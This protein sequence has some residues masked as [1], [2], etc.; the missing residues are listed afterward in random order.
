MPCSLGGIAFELLSGKYSEKFRKVGVGWGI[1]NERLPGRNLAAIEHGNPAVMYWLGVMV[2]ATLGCKQFREPLL[3]NF[4]FLPFVAPRRKEQ[5]DLDFFV[6]LH[7]RSNQ[8]GLE[9]G[10]PLLEDWDD[11][12]AHHLAKA[13]HRRVIFDTGKQ[14]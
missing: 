7:H 9:L 1:K 2:V 11:T 4:A 12:G 6:T 3:P 13:G 5:F 8:I 10:K 14:S